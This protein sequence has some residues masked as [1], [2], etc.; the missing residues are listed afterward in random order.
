MSGDGEVSEET[1]PTDDELL[2]AAA[3]GE[4]GF[5]VPDATG[6]VDV[7]ALVAERPS[8][9][10][11]Q[12]FQPVDHTVSGPTAPTDQRLA[13]RSANLASRSLHHIDETA[14]PF[15]G[16]AAPRLDWPIALAYWLVAEH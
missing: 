9:F 10:A 7:A 1:S 14:L 11:T 13:V 6:E 16:F 15:V 4:Q 3:G 8:G 2:E 5:E 12:C